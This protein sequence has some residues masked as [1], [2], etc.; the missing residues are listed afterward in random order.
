VF[1]DRV[2]KLPLT[3]P[4]E[5]KHDIVLPLLVPTALPYLFPKRSNFPVCAQLDQCF[6]CDR[7][8]LWVLVPN[9]I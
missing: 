4:K 5:P 1:H 9:E 8:K 2:V 3:K 6:Q 7:P